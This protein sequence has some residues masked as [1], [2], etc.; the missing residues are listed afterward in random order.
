VTVQRTKPAR[1]MGR[2]TLYKPEYVELAR[3][4]SKLGATD[5]QL[6]DIFGVSIP[7]L[8]SWK[9]RHAD[10]LAALKLG[11]EEADQAVTRSLY[12]RA[13]GYKTD[14]VK[15][16]L[17]K[18]DEEP[19]IVPYQEHVQPDTTACIFWLKN[20][21]PDLWRDKT[22]VNVT[23]DSDVIE[24]LQNARKQLAALGKKEEL[25]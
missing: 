1:K 6:A 3:K 23:G 11:K 4:V 10:F 16:F 2:P 9:V 13:M 24:R 18:G 5:D 8:R 22:D 17:R 20:R 19:V 7:T 14:A 12:Q 25:H 21:R 15:I